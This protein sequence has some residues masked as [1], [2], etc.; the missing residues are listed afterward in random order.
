[1]AIDGLFNQ[2]AANLAYNGLLGELR[3]QVIKLA[4]ICTDK[5]SCVA[6]TTNW[7]CQ[8]HCEVIQVA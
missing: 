8:R 3:A 7:Q 6:E 1:M 2:N 4:E 5:V